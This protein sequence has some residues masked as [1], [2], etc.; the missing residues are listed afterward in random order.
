MFNC[1][2][3]NEYCAFVCEAMKVEAKE[4]AYSGD[5]LTDKCSSDLSI[6]KQK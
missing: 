6:S 5:P 3:L 2:N 1:G 4:S